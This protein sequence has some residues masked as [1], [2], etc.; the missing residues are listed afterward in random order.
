MASGLSA[1]DASRRVK[2]QGMGGFISHIRSGYSEI[3]LNLSFPFS[4]FKR[5]SSKH[6]TFSGLFRDVM[7][8]LR[9]SYN[10]SSRNKN[11]CKAR[12]FT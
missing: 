4:Y 12:P 8:P 6:A 11:V 5:S 7:M 2:Y 10:V 1:P 9:C 3:Y